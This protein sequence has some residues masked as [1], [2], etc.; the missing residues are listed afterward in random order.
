MHLDINNMEITFEKSQNKTHS[1]CCV[2]MQISMRLQT[3]VGIWVLVSMIDFMP[4]KGEHETG[5]FCH[6]TEKAV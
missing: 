6:F 1:E 2:I 3:I 5:F 4:G